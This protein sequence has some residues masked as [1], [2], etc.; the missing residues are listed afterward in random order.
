MAAVRR[1]VAAGENV[2]VDTANL[3]AEHVRDLQAALAAQ[4]LTGKVIFC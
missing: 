3:S 1:E 4:G 2:I